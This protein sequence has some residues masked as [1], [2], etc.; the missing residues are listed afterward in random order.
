MP[1]AFECTWSI[2]LII[3]YI[4]IITRIIAIVGGNFFAIGQLIISLVIVYFL[5]RPD[6]KAH[7]RLN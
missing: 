6:A 2:T 3:S 1:L 5:Y 4:L 7:W